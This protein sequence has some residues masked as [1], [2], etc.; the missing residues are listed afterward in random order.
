MLAHGRSFINL[1]DYFKVV[2][3]LDHTL[4]ADSEHV[5]NALRLQWI[6]AEYLILRRLTFRT[7]L[8]ESRDRCCEDPRDKIYALLGLMLEQPKGSGPA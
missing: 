1:I 2:S 3:Y 7:L 5:N 6:N 8:Y 4:R